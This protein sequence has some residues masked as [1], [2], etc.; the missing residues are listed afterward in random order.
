MPYKCTEEQFLRDV[1]EHQL[2]V[3]RDDGVHRHLQFRRPGSVCMGFD[4]ITWPGY[5]CFCGDMGTYVFYR[6]EDMFS[7]F[8]SPPGAMDGLYINPSYWSEKC[9][10]AD[11]RGNGVREYDPDLFRTV[12]ADYIL[13]AEEDYPPTMMAELLEAVGEDVLAYAE[14]GEHEARRCAVNFEWKDFEF[15][16]FWE[17]ELTTFT[18]RFIWCCYAIVWGIRE[19]D[20]KR[21]AVG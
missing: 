12:I 5:I 1:A 18:F 11:C 4:L 20:R 3:I 19:Y 14:E 17:R 10:S 7:L 21:V 9:E 16:D 13:D 15:T 8:R 6:L 2:T